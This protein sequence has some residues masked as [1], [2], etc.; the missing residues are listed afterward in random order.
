MPGYTDNW[1]NG[2]LPTELGPGTALEMNQ[3]TSRVFPVVA[4]PNTIY[5]NGAFTGYA[6]GI[7]DCRGGLWGPISITATFAQS[8]P[9]ATLT[10]P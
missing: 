1:I 9:D 4:G 7:D 6:G 5:L 3:S 10:V 2:N 8:N